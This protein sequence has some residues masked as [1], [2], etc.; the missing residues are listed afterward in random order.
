MLSAPKLD[1]YFSVGVGP[2]QFAYVYDGRLQRIDSTAGDVL[3]AVP[4]ELDPDDEMNLVT[5]A[6]QL[7]KTSAAYQPRTS[8]VSGKLYV[9]CID[10]SN[11]DVQSFDLAPWNNTAVNCAPGVVQPAGQ[12]GNGGSK[13]MGAF[14]IGSTGNGAGITSF[15][16]ELL[17]NGTA[18]L[19]NSGYLNC[20]APPSTPG[21]CRG[22]AIRGG[23]RSSNSGA[24]RP[25]DIRC[26]RLTAAEQHPPTQAGSGRNECEENT[27]ET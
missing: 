11:L 27:A 17:A 22:C 19:S 15:G 16:F 24:L 10:G 3:D 5:G 20:H 8:V 18:S 7:C 23:A 9:S 2:N 12:Y 26:G 4:I 13:L 6:R 25:I 21:P 14:G 1:E